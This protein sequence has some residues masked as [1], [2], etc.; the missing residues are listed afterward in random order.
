MSPYLT[1]ATQRPT[2][3]NH[4]DAGPNLFKTRAT[5]LLIGILLVLLLSWLMLVQPLL[6]QIPHWES[7]TQSKGS[8]IG[9]LKSLAVDAKCNTYQVGFFT[10]SIQFGNTTLVSRGRSDVFVAKLSSAGTWDWAVAMG[11]AGSDQAAGVAIDATGRIFISGSFSQQMQLGPVHLSSQGS[12]DV[13]VAQISPQGTWQWAVA[14]GGSGLDRAV[15]LATSPTG[16]VVVG[17]QFAGAATFGTHQL[18]SN[19]GGDAFVARLASTGVWQWVIGAGSFDNDETSALALNAAGEIYATG[20]FSNTVRFGA[21]LL[22]GRGMDDAFVGKL[23][24]GGQWQ[25][26]TAATSTN[27]AYGK[28][29]TVDPAGGVFVTGSFWGDAQFGATRLTSIGATRLT[30]NSSDDG[31]VARLNE[32]GQ[33]QWVTVVASDNLESII[34]IALDRMGKLFVAGTFSRNLHGGS[35]QLTSRGHQD[36]FIGYLDRQGAWLGLVAGGG[37]ATDETQAMALAPS[38]QVVVG[39]NFSSAATFGGIHLQSGIPTAQVC[40]ARASVPQP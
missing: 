38:G 37:T 16:D 39:G 2:G 20:Y 27:T 23:S 36:V 35:F 4:D 32:A 21:S 22:S 12:M 30:S 18:M 1:P 19:G 26:A 3:R 25:W 13:F 29:I 5:N 9:Q 7:A 11:G 31:F 14:A 34:G 8:G 15:A 17:G 40:V 33:W 24:R 10:E 28:G 6:A